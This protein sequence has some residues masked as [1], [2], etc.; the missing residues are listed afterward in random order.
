MESGDKLLLKHLH[1]G[2]LGALRPAATTTTALGVWASFL[3][4]LGD[5]SER[6]ERIVPGLVQLGLLRSRDKKTEIV[7]RAMERSLSDKVLRFCSR[8]PDDDHRLVGID[9]GLAR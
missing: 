8:I 2:W 3:G 4:R 7:R 5:F 1:I 9:D 6:G